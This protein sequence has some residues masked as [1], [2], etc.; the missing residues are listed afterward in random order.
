MRAWIGVAGAL[1]ACLMLA[2]CLPSETERAAADF[3][4][5]RSYGIPQATPAMTQCQQRLAALRRQRFMDVWADD[6]PPIAAP[7]WT[8]PAAATSPPAYYPSYVPPSMPSVNPGSGQQW[9]IHP[10]A[11]GY[12]PGLSRFEVCN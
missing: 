4:R 12:A 10:P 7:S 11:C 1:G 9:L 5:C 8:S 3:D 6:P 2:G